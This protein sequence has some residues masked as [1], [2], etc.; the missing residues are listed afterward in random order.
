MAG[1]GGSQAILAFEIMDDDYPHA[2]PYFGFPVIGPYKNSARSSTPSVSGRMTTRRIEGGSNS[3][4]AGM[5]T[6]YDASKPWTGA[7][8]R[9][10]GYW[11]F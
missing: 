8:E 9:R 6:H 7:R 10:P 2:H 3:D 5:V 4:C 11:I 1:K